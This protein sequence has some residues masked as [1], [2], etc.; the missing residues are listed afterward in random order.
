[1]KIYKLQREQLINTSID[2][3]W[4]FFS[5]ARNLQALTPSYMKFNITSGQLPDKVYPGQIIT[6]KVSPLLGIPL[7]WVTEITQVKE[8]EYFIDEQRIGPY[9]IWHHE[10]H[11]KQ[12]ERGVLMKDIVY[13][14]LPLG[15]LGS[16]AHTLFV[17]NQLSNIFNYRYEKIEQ[18]FNKLTEQ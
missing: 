1:M 6:Y 13:Y 7:T 10:H 16:F 4:H 17:R 14:A 8:G 18:L 5:D 9:H 15:P 12:T 11:F 2:K 3:L